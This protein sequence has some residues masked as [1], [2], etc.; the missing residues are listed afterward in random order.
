MPKEEVY[1][2][3]EKEVEKKSLPQGVWSNYHKG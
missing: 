2:G 1:F 3:G